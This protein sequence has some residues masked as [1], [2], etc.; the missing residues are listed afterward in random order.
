M[1]CWAG[2][3]VH[4]TTVSAAVP[5]YMKISGTKRVVMMSS[6]EPAFSQASL[7]A[8]SYRRASAFSTPAKAPNLTV[9]A[10]VLFG[11]AASRAAPRATKALPVL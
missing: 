4:S 9:T 5:E 8:L 1:A 7:E 6:A 3:S 11:K 2:V 10:P